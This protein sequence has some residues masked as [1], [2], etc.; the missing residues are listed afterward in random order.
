MLMTMTGQT[1]PGTNP[2][3][4]SNPEFKMYLAA[5]AGAARAGTKRKPRLAWN[6]DTPLA[7]DHD[8]PAGRER[9]KEPPEPD[10]KRQKTKDSGTPDCG[11]TQWGLGPQPE[12]QPMSEDRNLNLKT[13]TETQ[14]NLKEKIKNGK[15]ISNENEIREMIDKKDRDTDTETEERNSDNKDKHEEE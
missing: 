9:P 6:L 11:E 7:K 14:M 5:V 1:R 12:P 4:E 13:K 15:A 8:E 10:S 3:A 2:N